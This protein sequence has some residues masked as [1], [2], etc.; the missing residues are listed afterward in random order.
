MA[1]KW[2]VYIACAIFVGYFLLAKGAPPVAVVAGI[3]GAGAWTLLQRKR[4]T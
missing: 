1:I 4:T 3:I 2:S